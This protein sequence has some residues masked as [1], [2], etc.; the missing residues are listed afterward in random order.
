MNIF[1]LTLLGREEAIVLAGL[2][3]CFS[4]VRCSASDLDSPATRSASFSTSL[5]FVL[6][7][8]EL[9]VLKLV[10]SS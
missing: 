4:C 1:M 8:M 3:V 9:D 10:K 7:N 6:E 2:L 5:I